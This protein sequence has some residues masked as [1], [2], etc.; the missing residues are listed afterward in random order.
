[1]KKSK[2]NWIESI[3][4]LDIVLGVFSLTVLVLVTFAGAIR[5]YFLKQPFVWQEEVQIWM[6]VWAIFSGAS[7]AF[8]CSAHVS[9]DVLV[10]AFPKRVQTIIEWFGV[11]CTV[12][13]L[14]FILVSSF[15]LNLQ[16]YE[17]GRRTAILRIPNYAI[18]WI[19][20]FSCFWMMVSLIYQM[21]KRHSNPNAGH[22]MEKG[23]DTL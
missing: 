5:R 16:Y 7:Y 4:N 17:M 2:K 14:L 19:V 15:R 11:F 9:I 12:A 21:Y 18:Y 3:L 6:I 8:R 10:E 20:P 13:V 23:G 1:M 22:D